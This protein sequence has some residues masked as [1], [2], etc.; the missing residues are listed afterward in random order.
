MKNEKEYQEPCLEVLHL[1]G[2]DVVTA[3]GVPWPD[4]WSDALGKSF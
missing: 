4:D 1:K 3:S 2:E